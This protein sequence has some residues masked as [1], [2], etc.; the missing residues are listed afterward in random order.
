MHDKIS[1]AKHRFIA[2]ESRKWVTQGLI[3]EAQRES[4]L[5]SYAVTRALPT[6]VLTLGFTMIGLGVLTFI[7]ANWQHLSQGFK[8]VLIVGGYLACVLSAFV[9]E[10][11]RHLHLA[12][13]LLFL[14]GFM[15]LGGI[16]LMSQIF[17]IQGSLQGLFAAWLIAY[18]PTLV[19]SRNIAIYILYECAALFYINFAYFELEDPFLWRSARGAWI[20]LRTLFQPLPPLLLLLLLAGIAWSSFRADRREMRLATKESLVQRLLVGGATRRIVL[21]NF[22]IVNWFTWICVMNSSGRTVLP[23]AFGLIALGACVAVAASRLDAPDLDLQGMLLIT[24]PAFF[25]T[26]KL[27][28]LSSVLLGAYLVFRIVRGARG[29]LAVTFFCALLLRWYVDMFSDFM[30]R[31]LFFISSGIFLLLVAFAYRRWNARR[32]SEAAANGGDADVA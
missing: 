2:D 32:Q 23:Y 16:A 12:A 28:L 27:P 25:L 10:K 21:C 18:L 7:A 3:G 17:H 31:S 1:D 6:V 15:L 14:S 5:G 24:I 19:L 11:R 20:D 30:P 13:S 22:Y 4:I 29:G 26:F 8:I 9:L